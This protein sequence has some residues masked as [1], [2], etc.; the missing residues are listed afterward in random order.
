M[1]YNRQKLLHQNVKRNL[2]LFLYYEQLIL[3]QELNTVIEQSIIVFVQIYKESN[4]ESGPD[5]QV[6]I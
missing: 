3:R 5:W 4:N 2:G 1:V 6:A